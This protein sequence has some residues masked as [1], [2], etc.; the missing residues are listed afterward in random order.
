MALTESFIRSCTT[1]EL[2]EALGAEH[3]QLYLMEAD[4]NGMDEFLD[5]LRLLPPGLRAMAVTFELEVQFT[6]GGLAY[7][8]AN[9][10]HKGY[11]EEALRGLREL[12]ADDAAEIFA[13]GF[14][15]VQP[16]WEEMDRVLEAVSAFAFDNWIRG[17]ELE[18]AL[19]PLN[20]QLAQALEK[21]GGVEGYWLACARGH[22]DKFAAT[23]RAQEDRDQ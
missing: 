4:A 10:H 20:A 1:E 3:S 21:A 17:S 8:F 11:C 13:K 22:P 2:R 16:H 23:M 6:F 12:R 9:R 15:L 7:F 19:A 5:R 14:A 18:K